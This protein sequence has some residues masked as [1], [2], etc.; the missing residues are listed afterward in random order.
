MESKK[1]FAIIA[2]T[3]LVGIF[4]ISFASAEFWACFGKGE[5]RDYCNNYKPSIT[6]THDLCEVCMSVYDPIEDCYISGNYLACQYIPKDC[7]TNENVTYDLTPPE[8]TLTSPTEGQLFTDRNVL[9]EF[10]LNEKATVSYTVLSDDRQRE[11]RLCY[12]CDASTGII[13]SYSDERIF[14]DGQNDVMFKAVDLVG[15]PITHNVSFFVD[16]NEP[17]IRDTEPNSGE[18]ASGAFSI[19][20]NEDNPV[21]LKLRINYTGG[22][23][24]YLINLE[25]Q[26]QPDRY[27][28]LCTTDINM[29]K[30]NGEDVWYGFELTDIV[31][32]KAF[33]DE[34][35][36]KVDS[37]F[38]VI[39]DIQRINDRRYIYF[40]LTFTEENLESITYVDLNDERS[41][42]RDLCRNPENG[43][44]YG[45]VSLRDGDYDL[46]FTVLDEAGN[47]VSQVRNI[48][49]DTK[50]PRIY[51][52]EPRRGFADGNFQVQFREDNPA[53]VTLHYGDDS[54]NLDLINDCYE[55]RSKV[56]CSTYVNLNKYDGEEIEYYFEIEDVV[57]Q[58]DE[59]RKSQVDVDTT[60]PILNN[61]NDFYEIDGRYVRFW[62]DITEEN[63]DSVV[64]V[65]N[66]DP[67]GYERRLCTRLYDG[68]CERR[69]SF[70]EG[71][72]ELTIKIMDEAGNTIGL[73][74]EFQINY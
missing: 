55:E 6:C 28:T 57:G 54:H 16:S 29:D 30:Y 15:N 24:E 19:E 1:T 36:V 35:M 73:P 69:A 40:N 46:Q 13:P 61:A 53:R 9:I 56:Y 11:L 34:E 70:R 22:V 72:Y 25:T 68:Y 17:R 44:C 12:E 49:I 45:R 10:F 41:R 58:I 18:Y 31:G 60:F 64:Y 39:H 7:S 42:P 71:N 51:K 65:D 50:S 74:A 27:D 62:F 67:R 23:D 33:S 20:F 5:V 3:L 38:P 8:F 63:F 32:N 14:S 59:S 26:C 48:F 4:L 37:T 52:T 66:N 21:E 47:A 2:L 43:F